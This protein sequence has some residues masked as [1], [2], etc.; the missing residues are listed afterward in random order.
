MSSSLLAIIYK[1]LG[2]NFPAPWYATEGKEKRLIETQLR[3]RTMLGHFF[4]VSEEISL[5]CV[6]IKC[7]VPMPDLDLE[8]NYFS[9]FIGRDILYCF[10]QFEDR[11]STVIIWHIL[12]NLY[13]ASSGS[14]V[15]LMVWSLPFPPNYP[16]ELSLCN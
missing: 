9:G 3:E 15:F 11:Q 8:N 10:L 7:L 5:G 1:K 4:E 2:S 16:L 12:V 14:I 6:L 13:T